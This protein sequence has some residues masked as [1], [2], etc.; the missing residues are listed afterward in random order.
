M[1]QHDP[2]QDPQHD[3]LDQT[4]FLSPESVD[5][6][7]S[8]V[9]DTSKSSH[10]HVDASKAK[11]NMIPNLPKDILEGFQ[12]AGSIEDQ[13][14]K[15]L[16]FMQSALNQEDSHH[17]RNFWEA[18]KYAL[19]LFKQAIQSTQRVHFWAQY[20]MI[21]QQAK[22]LK[23]KFDEESAFIAEQIELAIQ[24]VDEDLQTLST[25]LDAL[26]P[27]EELTH[28]YTLKPHLE[29]YCRM[30]GELNYLNVFSSRILSLKKELIKAEVRLKV[31][32][33]LF[34][35][36]ARVGDL[37]FPKRKELIQTMSHM[38]QNDVT[39]FMNATFIKDMRMPELFEAREEVKNLQ[40][41]AKILTLNT[42]AFSKT[43]EQL[44]ECWD[45][46]REV[47]Q[48]RKQSNQEMK[49]LHRQHKDELMEE[50]LQL[51]KTLESNE[52]AAND[53]DKI[54]KAIQ[55]KMRALSLSYQDVQALKA[56]IRLLETTIREL[57]QRDK[58]LV[59]EKKLHIEHEKLRK[60]AEI[61]E[62]IQNTEEEF[63]SNKESQEFS[64]EKIK[65]YK[66]L[67]QKYSREI[68]QCH[69]TKV[70]AIP[71]QTAIRE[72]KQAFTKAMHRQLV[73]KTSHPGA[74]GESKNH[75]IE[76]LLQEKAEIKRELDRL[77]KSRG[78]SGVN[79]MDAL[80]LNE[81][82]DLLKQRLEE[83]DSLLG[84]VQE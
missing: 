45:S 42:E 65:A 29:E 72:L 23:E 44:S 70:E 6:D 20:S 75:A 41:I 37:L 51:K 63:F 34:Q 11:N 79:F 58:A 25:K 8:S 2:Q 40:H 27:I 77:R 64:D 69:L 46:I 32:N 84:T 30:Q 48:E 22:L 10:S 57:L 14:Q 26:L 50:I 54:L 67:I 3:L 59:H 18:R 81:E 61:Q 60:I 56:E 76:Q 24:S 53:A 78:A 5:Q 43:R 66:E 52:I 7:A 13:L 80:S 74:Q 35:H 28:S 55:I 12:N 71:L 17:F 73:Q 36:L 33:K 15:V 83:V 49:V 4:N 38:F 82:I 9:D 39:A 62:R 16:E 31:K 19:I 1:T 47:I 21:C 68:D